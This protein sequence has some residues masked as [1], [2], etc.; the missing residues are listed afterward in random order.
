MQSIDLKSIEFFQNPYP[1]YQLI[2]EHGPVWVDIDEDYESK[3]LWVFGGYADA[4]EL[5]KQTNSVTKNYAAHKDAENT[6]TYDKHVLNQDGSSHIKMRSISKDLTSKNLPEQAKIYIKH[7]VDLLKE[8]ILSLDREIDLVKDFAELLPVR[9]ITRIMGLPIE[10]AN[11]FLNPSR[12]IIIDSFNL[13]QDD[14]KARRASIQF[15]QE[16]LSSLINSNY[17]FPSG[18]LLASYLKSEQSNLISRDE[19][20]ANAAFMINAG[21]VTTAD[22]ISNGLLL[23][24]THPDQLDLLIKKPVLWPSA[25]EEI[26]RFESPTQRT[27]F[28]LTKSDLCIAGKSLSKNTQV[29][30]LLG[31][32]NRDERVFKNADSFNVSRNP[33][34]HIAFGSGIHVCQGRSIARLEA[35]MA[36]ESL[37]PILKKVSLSDESLIWKN[38]GF[39]RGLTTLK[40]QRV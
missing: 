10:D 14:K 39:L 34:P 8:K 19:L 21:H 18:S 24:L 26:L 36:F 28:R 20:I 7:E 38:S 12:N 2:R 11:L 33:N 9:I 23:L 30:V 29:T 15:F 22:L 13:S 3:G 17:I 25:V 40:V 1:T 4:L 27:T 16:Y 6:L 37:A 35:Q 5:L 32:A 31:S